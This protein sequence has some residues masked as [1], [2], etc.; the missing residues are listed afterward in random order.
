MRIIFCKS[1][2]NISQVINILIV[3]K[4]NE[5]LEETMR[6]FLQ[7]DPKEVEELDKKEKSEKEKELAKCPACGHLWPGKSDTCPSCGH[8][9]ARRSEVVAVPGELQELGGGSM[10]SRE[11]KQRWYSELLGIAT[12]RGYAD[13]W[14]GHKFREKFGV[15][16]RS[17]ERVA[18]PPSIEV[19][20]WEK[21]RRIAWAKGRKAA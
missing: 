21:S 8:T 4:K 6:R 10:V 19:A 13:G 14:V 7:T 16:P 1:L 20:R 11:L 9:R 18:V 5:S 3:N 17:L 2:K 12:D 15:W